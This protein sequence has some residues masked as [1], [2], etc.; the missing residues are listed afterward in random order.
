MF[1]R[2]QC[3]VELV[4]E[5]GAAAAP[6]GADDAAGPSGQ[7]GCGPAAPGCKEACP[8]ATPVG[9]GEWGS[10]HLIS[11]S[12]EGSLL[13]L[14][15]GSSSGDAEAATV[16]QKAAFFEAMIRSN[17]DTLVRV[18][19]APCLACSGPSSHAA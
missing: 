15:L 8:V 6:S 1:W 9:S 16:R 5:A 19:A 4:G 2:K 13:E 11:A 10:S 18:G 14:G 7:D 17:T 3:E 12:S